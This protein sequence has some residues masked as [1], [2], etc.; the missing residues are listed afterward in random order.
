MHLIK[1][2]CWASSEEPAAL[3][4]HHLLLLEYG[5]KYAVLQENLWNESTCVKP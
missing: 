1:G 5:G 2:K 4:G 3:K